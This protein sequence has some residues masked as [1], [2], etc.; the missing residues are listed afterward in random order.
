VVKPIFDEISTWDES[1]TLAILPDHP[2]PC[3]LKTHTN[4]SVPFIIYRPDEQADDVITY[5]EFAAKKGSYG[6]LKGAEFI[7]ELIK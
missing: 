5:D 3:A 4:S 1:V 6:L 2:T 7:K